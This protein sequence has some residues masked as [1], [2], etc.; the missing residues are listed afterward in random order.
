MTQSDKQ[1]RHT[2][3]PQALPAMAIAFF[4][5]FLQ[6]VCNPGTT[7]RVEKRKVNQMPPL[8]H[9]GFLH[10]VPWSLDLILKTFLTLYTIMMCRINHKA[11]RQ[12][13]K[14]IPR[15]PIP[16]REQ[17]KGCFAHRNFELE[18]G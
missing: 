15:K 13:W 5:G 14:V 4:L 11:T 16:S 12:H 2:T 18:L 3:Q 17:L 9:G 10:L 6:Q 7:P 8:F 1:A